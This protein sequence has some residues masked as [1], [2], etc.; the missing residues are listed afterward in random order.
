M[1]ELMRHKF[2]ALQIIERI[3][4]ECMSPERNSLPQLVDLRQRIHANPTIRGC[5]PIDANVLCTLL[6]F[7]REDNSAHYDRILDEMPL[8]L[9]AKGVAEYAAL[10]ACDRFV[11][12]T[13]AGKKILYCFN[14]RYW[15]SSQSDDDGDVD[16]ALSVYLHAELSK[17]LLLLCTKRQKILE[18]LGN[19]RQQLSVMRATVKTL[20]NDA[21]R[22]DDNPYVIGFNDRV[23]D[24]DRAQFRP[25]RREDYISLTTDYDWR[26]PTA[27]EVAR[28]NRLIASIFPY[29]DERNLFIEFLASCLCGHHTDEIFVL[30]GDNVC[31]RSIMINLMTLMFGFHCLIT[32]NPAP[33]PVNSRGKRCV[34]FDEVCPRRDAEGFAKSTAIVY[35]YKFAGLSPDKGTREI[36]IKF[37]TYDVSET[38]DELFVRE[39]KYALFTILAQSFQTLRA[40]NFAFTVPQ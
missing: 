37:R 18:R 23:F 36:D 15:K 12:Q 21:I 25:Y 29:E 27:P 10:F 28:V 30:T 9:S 22:F 39:H 16:T 35:C 38:N 8:D 6:S 33:S 7:A 13:Y 26:E 14:G 19:A 3:I 34:I 17:I 5:M 40:R 24:L 2:G 11:W 4:F 20:A 1:A 31:G 32:N